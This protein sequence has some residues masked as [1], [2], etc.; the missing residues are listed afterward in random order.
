[1]KFIYGL[2]GTIGFVIAL[3]TVGGIDAESI[4]MS[5]AV[6]HLILSVALI[7]AAYVGY[8]LHEMKLARDRIMN[9]L[10][11]RQYEEYR[12]LVMQNAE[13]QSRMSA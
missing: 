10:H 7:G 3:L 9:S 2:M 13:T 4:A 6:M 12:R 11:R 1:M 8:R 5:E